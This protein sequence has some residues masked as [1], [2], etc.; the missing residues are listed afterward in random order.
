MRFLNESITTMKTIYNKEDLKEALQN[1][2]DNVSIE[3]TNLGN[4]LILV[5]RIQNGLIP[6][7]VIDRIESNRPC[8]FAV[9]EGVVIDVDDAMA[10]KVL[11]LNQRFEDLKIELD[12]AQV[13]N[14]QINLYYGK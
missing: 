1:K 11:S 4:L 12:V 9:G 8:K 13:V 6:E 2:E 7:V 3:N 10:K 14:T 5:Y